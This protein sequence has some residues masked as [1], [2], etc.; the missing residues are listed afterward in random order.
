M[1]WVVEWHNGDEAQTYLCMTEKYAQNLFDNFGTVST[2]ESLVMWVFDKLL[3]K[4]V[5]REGEDKI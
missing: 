1:F 5:W 2:T 4:R 3:E